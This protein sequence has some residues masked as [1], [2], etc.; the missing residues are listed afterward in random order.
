[1][2]KL[3]RSPTAT[4]PRGTNRMPPGGPP[5][6]PRSGRLTPSAIEARLDTPRLPS[7]PPQSPEEARDGRA[8]AIAPPRPPVSAAT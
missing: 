7:S 5:P 2:L 1:M 8:F 3:R 6:S 4:S